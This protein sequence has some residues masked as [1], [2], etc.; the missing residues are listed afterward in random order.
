MVGGFV[1]LQGG[2]PLLPLP[3]VNEPRLSPPPIQGGGEAPEPEAELQAAQ[4]T[5]LALAWPPPTWQVS[6]SV[7]AQVVAKSVKNKV[8]L[9]GHYSEYRLFVPLEELDKRYCK[10]SEQLQDSGGD[11]VTEEGETLP[12][13]D[14]STVEAFKIV[15]A[16]PSDRKTL[17]LSEE[18]KV[19]IQLQ[20]D[21]HNAD[22]HKELVEL[23]RKQNKSSRAIVVE[24][25]NWLKNNRRDR[26]ASSAL[27]E[28]F[29]LAND[30][31]DDPEYAIAQF[32][33]QMSAVPRH[34]DTREYDGW[35]YLLAS[36]LEQRGRPQ[37]ALPLRSELARHVNNAAW[38]ADY[39][40]VL[41]MLGKR[42]EAAKAFRRAIAFPSDGIWRIDP[43]KSFHEGFAEALLRTGD[44]RGA[45][46]EYRASLSWLRLASGT[47]GNEPTDSRLSN[48]RDLRRASSQGLAVILGLVKGELP[49][50][51]EAL[52]AELRMKLAHVLLLE[53]KYDDALLEAKAALV[54]DRYDFSALYLQAEIHDAKGD[55]GQADKI[56]AAAATAIQNELTKELTND[57]AFAR[58]RVRN[59]Q[60]LEKEHR[61]DMDPRFLFLNDPLWNGRD[62]GPRDG[63]AASGYPA[64]PSEIISILEPR[65]HSLTASEQVELAIAYF[66]IGRTFGA[67]EQWERAMA[68]DSRADIAVGQHNLGEELVNGHAFADALPHLRRACELDPK[69]TTFRMDYDTI[70][71]PAGV[72]Q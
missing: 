57:P 24:D 66:A 22:A 48:P 62:S 34:D 44:L 2:S 17:G 59:L 10:A 53:K 13:G 28:I 30:Q 32:R 43:P 55:L 23:L 14:D 50:G 36:D 68:S 47:D 69:N 38:W 20:R 56:R 21:P 61:M 26:S 52:F 7:L 63:P 67:K 1:T 45:E 5:L 58:R 11:I 40:H 25:T 16:L 9:L 39:G 35:S 6:D 19:R 37:E 4:M 12:V 3:A 8:R 54:A 41:S 71:Q 29:Y 46:S 49:Y 70:R 65:I 72:G 31:L 33:L 15:K 64:F 60:L 18:D 42:E 51:D 27:D